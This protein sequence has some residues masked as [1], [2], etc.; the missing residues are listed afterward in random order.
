MYRRRRLAVI[1]LVLLVMAALA[2]VGVVMTGMSGR[3][4]DAATGGA[5][6]PSTTS[7]PTGTA[8]SPGPAPSSAG[9]TTTPSSRAP[10]STAPSDAAPSP[11]ATTTLPSPSS[12]GCA[13]AV[14]IAAETDRQTYGP[15]ENPV[16]SL[17]V[18]NTGERACTVNVGTSQMEF[19]LTRDHERVFSSIDCQHASQDLER[20]IAP[21]GEERA[22][23]EWDRNRT[24][25]GCT[26]MEE[27]PGSGP[28]TLTTRLGARS[29]SPVGFTLE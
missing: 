16:L 12:D 9:P 5:G 2:V 18:R 14:V 6:T 21:G 24:G 22:T 8:A 27:E 13:A 20:T 19:V 17:V 29:S 7:A 3:G 1:I 11:S 4:A 15:A 10:S 28:Y 25:P 26:L 23:F